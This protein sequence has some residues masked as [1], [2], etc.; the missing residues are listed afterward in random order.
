M[1]DDKWID[2][3]IKLK[4]KFGEVVE[5]TLDDSGEDDMGHK[6]PAKI[7]TLEFD[8]PLGHLKIARTTRPKIIDK[9]T[10]YHKGAGGAQVEY[11]LS[12]DEFSH[13]IEVT[14]LDETTGEWK[15]LDLPTES[16]SF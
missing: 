12:E 8:S 10:H 11:I 5:T 4:E 6:I 1:T 7:E 3:K 13:K 15:P 9:K 2:L 16:F 14:K